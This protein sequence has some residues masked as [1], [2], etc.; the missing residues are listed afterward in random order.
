VHI[1]NL[2]FIVLGVAFVLLRLLAQRAGKTK[3]QPPQARQQRPVGNETEEERI[4]RFL[5][6]LGQ[7][8]TAKPPPKVTPRPAVSP[9]PARPVTQLPQKKVEPMRRAMRKVV[10]PGSLPPL[11]TVPPPLPAPAP[12]VVYE[13]ETVAPTVVDA[14]SIQ[15]RK[16]PPPIAATTS[17]VSLKTL[18]GSPDRLRQAIVLREIFGPPRAFQFDEIL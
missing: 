14:P 1:D 9:A 10:L 17:D 2:V 6:A 11:T 7:P 16:L 8:T 12:L 3:E 4:R 15:V 13:A 18:L 5:E